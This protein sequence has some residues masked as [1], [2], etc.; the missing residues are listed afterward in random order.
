MLIPDDPLRPA[1]PAFE[2]AWQAEALALADSLVKAGVF[3]APEW[4]DCLGTRLREAEAAGAPDTLDTYYKAVLETVEA[5]SAA[6]ADISKADQAKRRA[7]WEAAYL[8]TP[9]GQPVTL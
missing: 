9:H 8:R 1:E 6:R 7:E 5:L 3:S 2:A 4:S